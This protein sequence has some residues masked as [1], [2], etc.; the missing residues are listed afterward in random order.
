MNHFAAIQKKLEEYELD[1]M[2]VTSPSNRKY[3]TDFASSAGM[4][5]VT[6]E[7]AW[8]FIDSRYIEAAKK[9]IHGAEVDMVDIHRAYDAKLN[10][11]IDRLGIR[12]LGVEEGEI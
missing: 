4:V 3:T 8:F 7:N 9:S 10:E 5:L 12:T 1:A 2:L 6:R 11:Q